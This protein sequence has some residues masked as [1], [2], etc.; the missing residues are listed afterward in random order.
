MKRLLYCVAVLLLFSHSIKADSGRFSVSTNILDYVRLATL[1]VDA[2]Y[3]LSRHWSVL[4]GARY[5]PL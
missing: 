3:A 5:N 2:S 1:N 4:A